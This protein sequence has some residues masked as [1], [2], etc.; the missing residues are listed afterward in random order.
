LQSGGIFLFPRRIEISRC[1]TVPSSR[2]NANDILI[3]FMRR[4]SWIMQKAMQNITQASRG[5]L[6]DAEK[7]QDEGMTKR[8]QF[9]C[10]AEASKRGP[11]YAP[12]Y[13]S[14]IRHYQIDW[15]LRGCWALS[16]VTV[17]FRI[18][19]TKKSLCNGDSIMNEQKFRGK[20]CL[21]AYFSIEIARILISASHLNT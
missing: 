10:T 11:T 5:K 9:R 3:S 21:C 17:P 13:H 19:S 15:T 2:T 20:I 18:S 1:A 14:W 4:T 6:C 12:R 7:T 16:F 8:S